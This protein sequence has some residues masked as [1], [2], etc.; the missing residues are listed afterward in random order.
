MESL[1]CKGVMAVVAVSSSVA[2]VAI[3]VHKRL[4]SDF[5]NKVHLQFDHKEHHIHKR[6]TTKKKKKVRFAADVIE[7][8]SNNEE[9]RRQW[10]NLIAGEINTY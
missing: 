4:L 8:S 6:D 10:Q 3:Q 2:F 9:Y 5:M 1:D 7:P